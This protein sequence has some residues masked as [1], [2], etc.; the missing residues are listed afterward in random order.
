MKS[1][2]G[3]PTNFGYLLP[4]DDNTATTRN[5]KMNTVPKFEDYDAAIA[6]RVKE[7]LGSDLA[8]DP[9]VKAF[10]ELLTSVSSEAQLDAQIAD[11]TA[12]TSKGIDI[13]SEF[14]AIRKHSTAPK[15]K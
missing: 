13:L 2:P 5:V 4:A 9:V 7:K 15:L 10:R 11:G 12:K 14:A 8:S 3:I 6:G 1:A